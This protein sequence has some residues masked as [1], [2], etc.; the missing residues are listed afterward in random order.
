[1]AHVISDECISC[2]ACADTCPVNAIAPGYMDT[3]MNVA[4]TD[5]NN[6]RCQQI[7]DRIPA[8][9]WGTPDD[10]KGTVIFLASAAS[11]YL[12]GAVIPVDGGYLVK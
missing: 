9:R 3:D 10:M 7:V 12:G 4:L 6:P 2:G 5:K 8:G 1:M 11:D